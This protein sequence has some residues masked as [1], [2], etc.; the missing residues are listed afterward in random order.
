[1]ATTLLLPQ[2]HSDLKTQCFEAQSQRGRRRG[3]AASPLRPEPLV[4]AS[5][6]VCECS[7]CVSPP[8][9]VTQQ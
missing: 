8:P 1:M 9:R 4:A 2:P 6:R 7:A 5:V 3:S